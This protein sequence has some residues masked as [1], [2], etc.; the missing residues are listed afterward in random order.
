[1]DRFKKEVIVVICTI[2][3]LIGS[4]ML[5]FICSKISTNMYLK[6]PAPDCDV[7]S[8]GETLSSLQ[9]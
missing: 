3:V 2:L 4:L 7:L 1:M 5:V 6:Y 8:K 9:D